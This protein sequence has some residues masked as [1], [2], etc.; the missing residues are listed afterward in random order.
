M[1]EFGAHVQR[2]SK[3]YL[4]S[5]HK[6]FFKREDRQQEGCQGSCCCKS[7]TRNVLQAERNDMHSTHNLVAVSE[8]SKRLYISRA[9]QFLRRHCPMNPFL[10]ETFDI[11]LREQT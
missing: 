8:I 2:S 11:S 6:Q 3:Y 9:Q 5:A 4:D 10:I 7:Q 1:T